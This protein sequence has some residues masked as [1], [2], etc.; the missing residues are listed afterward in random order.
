MNLT[1][2]R[3]RRMILK[4]MDMMGGGSVDP[5]TVQLI[6]DTIKYFGAAGILAAGHLAFL[7]DSLARVHAKAQKEQ[8]PGTDEDNFV[9]DIKNAVRDAAETDPEL[10]EYIADGMG[11]ELSSTDYE[12]YDPYGDG[13]EGDYGEYQIDMGGNIDSGIMHDDSYT[14]YEANNPEAPD[15]GDYNFG[16]KESAYADPDELRRYSD[17]LDAY[18]RE[19]GGDIQSSTLKEARRL[20]R[21]RLRRRRS[22]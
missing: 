13:T 6:I 8:N 2:N 19:L 10:S 16:S 1:R 3:L 4:E 18:K 11:A 7:I 5:E 12:L 14:D 21:R 17:D 9:A 20:R 15:L 22:V